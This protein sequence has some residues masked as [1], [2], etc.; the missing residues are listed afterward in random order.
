VW[1][2]IS[3]LKGCVIYLYVV[4][5]LCILPRTGEYKFMDN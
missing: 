4:I 5:L 3:H 1:E 2:I